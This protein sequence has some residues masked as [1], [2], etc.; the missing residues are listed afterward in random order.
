MAIRLPLPPGTLATLWNAEERF[1]RS[2]LSSY[3]GY[4]ETGDAGTIDDDGYVFVMAR[5]DD[6]INVAGHRLSTGAME[7]VLA[8]HPDVAECAVIG[9]A[10]ALKGQL[11]LGFL[12][13]NRGCARDP[14]AIVAE[15]VQLVRDRI[16]PVAAFSSAVVVDRLPKTRS[17]KI[18]RGVMSRMADGEAWKMPATIDDPVILHEIGESLVRIGL[19]PSEEAAASG[20]DTPVTTQAINYFAVRKRSSLIAIAICRKWV[21]NHLR[22][23]CV[24][25]YNLAWKLLR[26]TRSRGSRRPARAAEER[27]RRSHRD[28]QIGASLCGAR[29]RR[30]GDRRGDGGSG[31]RRRAS[32]RAGQR[33]QAARPSSLS[34]DDLA[35]LPQVTVKTENEFADGMVTYRGPLVRDVLA[36]LGLD[37]LDQVRFVAANDYY[38]DIP[39]EDFADYDAILAMEANGEKLS[40]REKGPLWLM[41]PI[42]DHAELKDPIY[43]RTADLAGRQDRTVV[44][45]G[46]PI[47]RY[48][49]IV[50]LLAMAGFAS[51]GFY[52]IRRDVENLRE[53]SQD[54]TQW[55]ASQM[56][57]E[58]LR[59]RLALEQLR[60]DR[61]TEA[62]D[63]MHERFD[64]L[65]SRVFMMGHGHVGESLLRYDGQ[66]GSVARDRRLPR[67]RSTPSSPR[68]T[69]CATGR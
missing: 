40:R 69:R 20:A 23:H 59:F 47:S 66:H 49:G 19:S 1:V 34:L 41:Y 14:E 7:E 61:P 56:E 55:S 21:K 2:Y 45:A 5:T 4:Y 48:L 11:P 42:S 31:R 6:V 53:I 64:I 10:D 35:A 28:A 67:R 15:C 17:G 3:P 54:N 12:C 33:R 32:A 8:S 13:L 46:R 50:V 65:W 38:V 60:T 68:S 9:I 62:L 52:T 18:L 16:G 39:T 58:L 51:V 44:S 63:N 36:K 37:K 43:L 26:P 57:I 30:G 25:R 24:H 29:A 22:T 27:E